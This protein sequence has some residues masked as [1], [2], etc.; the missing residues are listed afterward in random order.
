V[1]FT[2]ATGRALDGIVDDAAWAASWGTWAGRQLDYFARCAELVAPL[3]WGD[4]SRICGPEVDALARVARRAHARLL[5]DATIPAHL[6]VGAFQIVTQR[7]DGVRCV[8]HSPTDAIDL[9]TALLRHLPS[10]DG[11]PTKNVLDEMALQH[12]VGIEP[13]YLRRL[14]D[15]GILVA[16]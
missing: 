4:V 16:T 11:R 14:V 2:R 3:E 7:I 6:R 13:A 15:W 9:P 12:G 5:D 10:F 8:T 1:P